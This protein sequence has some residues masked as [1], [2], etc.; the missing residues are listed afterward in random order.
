MN[1]RIADIIKT[2]QTENLSIN[3]PF[4]I[5]EAGENHEWNMDLAFR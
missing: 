5:A 1:S 3:K 2:H 4:L